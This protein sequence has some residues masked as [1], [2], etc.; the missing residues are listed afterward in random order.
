MQIISYPGAFLYIAE[1]GDWQ[2][3]VASGVF[4]MEPKAALWEYAS[5][6]NLDN[7]AAL[8]V[9]AKAHAVANGIDWVNN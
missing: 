2:I 4:R 5:G 7:L 8:I 9:A 3:Y 6:I 1:T